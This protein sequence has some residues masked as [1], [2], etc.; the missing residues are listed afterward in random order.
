MAYPGFRSIAAGGRTAFYGTPRQGIEFFEKCGYPCP[1]NYNP[2]D[3]IIHTL[4]VVPHEE[5]AC[6]TRIAGICEK[7]ESGYAFR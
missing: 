2:A 6:R 1:H 3:L 5:E 4:A 7:F